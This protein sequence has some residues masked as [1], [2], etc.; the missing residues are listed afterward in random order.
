MGQQL[1]CLEYSGLPDNTRSFSLRNSSRAQGCKI[2]LVKSATGNV[3]CTDSSLVPGRA[4]LYSIPF[5]TNGCAGS[6]V[7]GCGPVGSGMKSGPYEIQPIFDADEKIGCPAFTWPSASAVRRAAADSE[8]KNAEAETLL[9]E[10]IQ[11]SGFSA[12][13]IGSTCWLK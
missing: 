5:S 8:R 6:K 3:D 1:D 7:I 2:G 13:A 9:A 12:T 4:A 11:K 10:I